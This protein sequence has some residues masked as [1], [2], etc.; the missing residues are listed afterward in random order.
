MRRRGFITAIAAMAWT[1]HP[2][3]AQTPRRVRIGY[4]SG[5]SPESR[6]ISIEVLIAALRDFGWR[7]GET[8]EIDEGWANG[9]V[10]RIP[11]LAA[12]LVTRHPDLLVA[13]GSTGA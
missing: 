5:G 4:L 9:E 13:T 10:F 2:L 12:E 8:L 1:S 7:I 6:E 11:T 3:T